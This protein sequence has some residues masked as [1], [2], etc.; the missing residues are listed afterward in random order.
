MLKRTLTLKIRSN[1]YI[2]PMGE[3]LYMMSERHLIRVHTTM[4]DYLYY[5]RFDDVMPDLDRRFSRCHRSYIL[6]LDRIIFL[7]NLKIGLDDRSVLFFGK[8]TFLRLK[9]ELEEYSEWKRIWLREMDKKKEIQIA[10][11]RRP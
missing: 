4:G 11:A 3:I 1:I 9:K 10:C 7:D 2:V 5:A 6:N 8:A